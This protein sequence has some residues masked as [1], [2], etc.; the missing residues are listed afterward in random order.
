MI[1]SAGVRS[2]DIVSLNPHNT[3]VSIMALSI[4]LTFPNN[5]VGKE[6]TCNAGDPTSIPWSERST[7]EVIVYPLQYSWASLLAQLGKNPL[8][9]HNTILSIMAVSIS[10]VV[11]AKSIQVLNPKSFSEKQW[12]PHVA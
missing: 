11:E 5:S 10:Q 9:P 6:S 12:T 3:I 8:N 2:T 7:G 1:T 4:L